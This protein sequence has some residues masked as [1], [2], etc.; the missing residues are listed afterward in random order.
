M[1]KIV[2][3]ISGSGSNLQAIIDSCNRGYIDAEITCVISNN[4]SAYGLER[5][6]SANINSIVINHKDYESRDRY[7]SELIKTLDNLNP[8]LIVLAGFMRILS[9]KLTDKFFGKII[10]IHPSLLPKYPGLNT[11]QEVINNNDSIHGV[12]IHY[13]SSKLDCGPLIAQGE[14]KTANKNIDILV[15]RIHKLEHELYPEIIKYICDD[16][17]FIDK[18]RVIFNDLNP[19]GKFI[20]KKYEI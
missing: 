2:V 19:S 14:I 7:D 16:K 10:N 20:Y 15:E 13:V 12:S 4:P 6:A 5:A 17:I 11:H 18:D 9:E 1:K 8:D 3:M